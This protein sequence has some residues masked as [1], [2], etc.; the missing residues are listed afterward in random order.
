[1]TCPSRIDSESEFLF[2]PRV[3]SDMSSFSC[4]LQPDKP[5][6]ENDHSSRFPLQ[7]PVHIESLAAA[8]RQVTA[9]LRVL[10]ETSVLA[11]CG[12]RDDSAN[13]AETSPHTVSANTNAGKAPEKPAK[14]RFPRGEHR[15][16]Q[17]DQNRGGGRSLGEPVSA[18]IPVLQGKY[19]ELS[20][21]W[22][23]ALGLIL[24]IL[25]YLQ[26]RSLTG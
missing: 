22:A 6:L 17:D 20:E 18:R 7:K 25:R 11:P 15:S 2:P 5:A 23:R 14:S 10:R 1:M 26:L 13:T 19:R 24:Q 16:L 9:S 4:S 8:L 21:L 12:S 3:K